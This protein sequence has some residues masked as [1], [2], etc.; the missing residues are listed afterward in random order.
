MADDLYLVSWNSTSEGLPTRDGAYLVHYG[1]GCISVTEFMTFADG[2]TKWYDA[3]D[4][5]GG[6]T[7]W[8]LIPPAPSEHA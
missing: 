7:H 3:G 5:I 6:V 8:M 4:G 2:R 1:N